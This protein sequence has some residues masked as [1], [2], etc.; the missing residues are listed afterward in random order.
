MRYFDI[1]MKN[2]AAIF[3]RWILFLIS[4]TFD[5]TGMYLLKKCFGDFQ[6]GFISSSSVM[7]ELFEY[8]FFSFLYF[9][10]RKQIL[11][12][13]DSKLVVITR[14]TCKKCNNENIQNFAFSPRFSLYGQLKICILLL[15]LCLLVTRKVWGMCN[16]VRICRTILPLCRKMVVCSCGTLDELTS[17][18]CSLRHTV[19]P[20]L[21]ATGIRKT[22]GWLLLA[23]TKQLRYVRISLC[24]KNTLYV[25]AIKCCY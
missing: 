16:S 22:L 24:S 3:Y 18:R 11:L 8:F 4:V 1:R 23:E 12:F 5:C 17:V 21:L 6:K 25:Q 13:N 7:I 9:T 14:I 20:F 19:D 15:Y 10:C 2:A